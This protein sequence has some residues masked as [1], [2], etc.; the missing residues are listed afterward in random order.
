[1]H[2]PVMPPPRLPFN[3]AGELDQRSFPPRA[4]YNQDDL[5]A[6]RETDPAHQLGRGALNLVTGVMGEG[7]ASAPETA[8]VAER[9]ALDKGVT[10]A[11]QALNIALS[12]IPVERIVGWALKG[13]V[14]GASVALDKLVGSEPAGLI[15][16]LLKD[17]RGSVRIP[18]TTDPLREGE[19]AFLLIGES[20]VPLVLRDLRADAVAAVV[21]QT[22]AITVAEGL[23]KRGTIASF[24]A[25]SE[26]TKGLGGTYQAHHIF[27]QKVLKM[28]GM[29]LDISPAVVLRKDVHAQLSAALERALP[30]DEVEEMTKAEI[31]E[32]YRQVYKD[33]PQWI[34]EVQRYL[35]R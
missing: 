7:V 27:E 3:Q 14:G 34:A 8:A 33:Y 4:V 13:V 29:P 5:K 20:K 26:A 11:E 23:A 12:M 30:A 35:G 32:A 9:D 24:A 17:S 31:L 19:I 18:F 28:L 2:D 21:K 15:R 6:I 22:D 1:M 16:A 10:P 25:L